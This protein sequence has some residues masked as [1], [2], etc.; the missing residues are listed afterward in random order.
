MAEDIEVI[1]RLGSVDEGMVDGFRQATKAAA[2]LQ[3]QTSQVSKGLIAAGAAVGAA[4]FAM[5]KFGKS[6]F[7]SAARVSELNVAID[8]IGKS[9]GIGAKTINETA[10][11]IAKQGIEMAAA[12]QMAIEYAQGNLN[13][14]QASEI[15]RVGQD[16]AVIS[17]K[18]STD[19]AQLLTRAIKT[20]NSMLLKSAGV[21][22]MASEGYADYA[23]QLGKNSTQL[24]ATER[25]QA[26]INLILDEG[27]KVAGVYEAAMQEP[28]KVLRSFPRL[29]ND[30]QVAFGGALLKGFGPM[31]KAAYDLTN[32]FSKSVKEGGALY[33]FITELGAA[34]KILL[35]PF[36]EMMVGLTNT[37]KRFKE[38]G[39][40]ADGAAKSIQKFAPFV[41]AAATA[42]STLAGRGILGMIGPLAKFQKFLNPVTAG[43]A[44][45]IALNPKLRDGFMRIGKALMPLIPAFLAIGK[46]I[47]DA[48]T[49]VVD[50]LGS[51]VDVLSGPLASVINVVADAFKFMA[52]FISA[53]SPVLQPLIIL[54]GVKYVASLLAVQ[55]ATI[56]TAFASGSLAAQTGILGKVVA[57]TS[58]LWTQYNFNLFTTGKIMP[59]L[60]ATSVATFMAIKGAIMSTMAALG[61]M[62]L[63]TVG[64]MALMKVFQAFSD[65]NKQLEE[66]TKALTEAANSQ[67][68]ALAKNRVELGNYLQSTKMT[69][70]TIAQTAEDGEKL[71]NALHSVGREAADSIGVLDSFQK[72]TYQA[73]YALALAKTGSAEA[74]QEIA[75][76]VSEFDKSK[77][78]IANVSA[79][80]KD[81]ALALEEIDDQS[82][83]TDISKFVQGQ[84]DAVAALGKE[85]AAL[86]AATKA[87]VEAD[88]AKRGD[89]NTTKMYLDIQSKVGKE[90][91][92]LA[93]SQEK[94]ATA[95]DKAKIATKSMVQ[96]LQ[97]LKGA[98]DDG[99]V[100][101]EEMAKALYGLEAFAA[102]DTAKG[103]ME[104]R[105][106]MTDL[107]DTVK[108]SKGNFDGLTSAG[109]QLFDMVA[110]NGV[111]MRE[112][113]KSNEEVAAMQTV[114]IERFMGSAKAAGFTDSAVK[115]LLDSMGMLS[116]FRPKV[117]IDADIKGFEAKIKAVYA[118]LEALAAGTNDNQLR[119]EY[120]DMLS[121]YKQAMAA[122]QKESKAYNTYNKQL[123]TVQKNL[124][125]SAK[126]TKEVTREKERL[127]AAIIKVVKDALDKEVRKLEEL[128]AKLDA[129]KSATR[130]A[131]MGA[132][133][134]G[135]A[136]SSATEQAQKVN[137]ELQ[138]LRDQMESFRDGVKDAVSGSFSMSNA[139]SAQ[140]ESAQ[141]LA[142][143][144]EDVAT[145]QDEVAAA[146]KRMDEAYQKY[147]TARGRKEQREAYEELQKAAADL[148]PVQQK[149]ADATGAAQAAQAKQLA[150]LDRLQEQ[151]DR[152]KGFA[153]TLGELVTL[154][155]SQDALREIVAAGA[156]TGGA[157][158]NELIKG[159]STA[160]QRTNELFAQIG[161][162]AK[163]TGKNLADNFYKIGDNVG[164]DFV[165][166]LAAQANQAEVFATRVR[167]LVAAGFAPEAIQ[168]VLDAGVSAGTSIADALLA[169]G[170]QAVAQSARLHD[171]LREAADSLQTLLGDKFYQTGIDL[172]QK[173]VDGLQAKLDELPDLLADMTIP[174]LKDT[175]NNITTEVGAVIAEAGAATT[176]AA[177][178]PVPTFADNPGQARI[179]AEREAAA[180]LAGTAT[181]GAGGGGGGGIVADAFSYT[182]AGGTN[183]FG[184]TEAM[185]QAN[186]DAMDWSF[187][188]PNMFGGFSA[189]ANGG[190]VN[191]AQLGLVGEA[192]PEAI[193]PLSRLE[194]MMAGGG[195]TINLTVNAGMGADGRNISDTIVNELIKYQRRNGKIPVVTL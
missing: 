9:S 92:A 150:F 159:G 52:Y 133:N 125:G 130:D 22:R 137:D 33:P 98:A 138:T 73:A 167:E 174:E 134:F 135:S 2:Q 62:L 128:K 12:Q 83:K 34:L 59:A 44:V 170:E 69:G 157:M 48:T 148:I 6:S 104:M 3:Q 4:A 115:Q 177:L 71:T 182:N 56:K 54:F 183:S 141:E 119:K 35:T 118:S 87:Q 88:Y 31:I 131:I 75:S 38:M 10:K 176:T 188:D 49:V 86:V 191:S 84:L 42:L 21:S 53:I 149:L 106:G 139:L 124:E 144:N 95:T 165:A 8:A 121:G 169:G 77:A 81:L 101:A 15:A 109:F 47:A 63:I 171:S 120:L 78:I 143:A 107:M 190:I 155:L 46:A 55:V 114:L 24:T 142:L 161:E 96:R 85:E 126:D 99:K 58:K 129:L 11:A 132:Y 140:Q 110:S 186:L 40:S 14:A 193:I 168:Q 41:M 76:A 184:L 151:A 112:L 105:K 164:A 43:I 100:S 17:Q 16:L 127:R 156:E 116:G 65:R 18:N 166:A 181:S 158:A 194:G 152:A 26:I 180:L 102:V 162:V 66:R 32:A 89:T 13:M 192:G 185:V 82:E 29:L 50:N 72:N 36:K 23:R 74:A 189:F 61:P 97:E 70:K 172:A 93:K 39:F 45:L 7:D 179:M 60:R 5:Y 163:N 25:Q 103:I 51:M 136:W 178:L 145:A 19:T 154:G 20:G 37:I 79:E 64:I 30:M 123:K 160:I 111:K 57:A 153:A 173:I 94:Q 108:E 28:G 187:L 122:L 146:N 147:N 68:K 1:A 80:Y 90:L 175:L 67:V 91:I 113:G 27:A 117:V 195:T